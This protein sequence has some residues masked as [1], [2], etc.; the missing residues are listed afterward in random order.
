[1]YLRPS[2]RKKRRKLTNMIILIAVI[3]AAAVGVFFLINN[4]TD[5]GFWK[6]ALTETESILPETVQ[7]NENGLVYLT[8]DKLTF[9]DLKGKTVW[10]TK[11]D[12]ADAKLSISPTMICTYLGKNLQAVSYTQQ[13][14]FSSAVASDIL[15]VRCGK[16]NIAVSGSAADETGQIMYYIYILNS[17]GEQTGQVDY[18]TRPVIDF[19]FYGDNDTLWVLSLDT[20]NVVPVSNIST[21]TTTG[22]AT[23]TIQD[24]TQIIEQVYVADGGMTYASGTNTLVSYDIS[25]KKQKEALIYGWKPIA[26]SN[27][28]T[29]ELAYIPR[30]TATYFESVKLFNNELSE[31]VLHMPQNVFSIALSQ[32]KL[33]AFSPDSVSTYSLT[34]ELEKTA[35][36]NNTLVSA[37]QVM[38]TLAIAWD[39]EGKSYLMPLS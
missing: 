32:Q 37:K 22:K 19:G 1:M 31:T 24:N 5:I 28:K 23:S 17:K 39:Q 6:P 26:V 18:K 10:D 21:Y 2:R 3:A 14:L 9:A 38:D 16:N 27:G 12:S 20:S 29:F 4:F 15:D 8:E 36:I 11:L 34:G 13:Q 25:S 35:K 30:S 7:G 33:Y